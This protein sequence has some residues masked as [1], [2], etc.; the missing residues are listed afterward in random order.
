M[1][2]KKQRRPA[3]ASRRP[4][5][6]TGSLSRTAQAAGA[7]AVVSAF[8]QFVGEVFR[9]NGQLLATAE[10]MSRSINVTPA[11][12]QTIATLRHEPLTV[13]QVARQ[14]GL[15]RQS[16]QHNVNLLV[17]QG[18]AELLPNPH[19]RRASLVG[20]TKRGQTVMK[21]LYRLQAELTTRFVG[22]LPLT[23]PDI[24]AMT[25][26]LQGIRRQGEQDPA[27]DSPE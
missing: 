23:A 7:E 9:L 14:L 17:Q 26:L 25:T 10:S 16:V 1:A 13:A 24:E 15:R 8:Q 20:L 22:T 4:S 21:E 19:H 27:G 18:L 6:R 11:R 5:S 3:R 12:W 2:T